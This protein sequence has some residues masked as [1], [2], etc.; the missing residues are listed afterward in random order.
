[1]VQQFCGY[2]KGWCTVVFGRDFMDALQSLP[3]FLAGK[4]ESSV[5]H[6][7]AREKV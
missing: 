2:K 3:G 4:T 5:D 7:G 6:E 1:M